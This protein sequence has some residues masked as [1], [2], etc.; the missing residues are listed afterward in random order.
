MEEL[1]KYIASSLV[2][3]PDQV[4]V[5]QH[6]QSLVLKVAEP[7]LG[8]IIGRQGR[9]IKAMRILINAIAGKQGKT[10]NLDVVE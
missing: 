4:R 8:K 7:D 1:V 6:D 5:E 3:H 9:T 10:V 2:D